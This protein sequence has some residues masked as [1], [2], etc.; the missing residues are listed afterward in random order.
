M[1]EWFL[2][3]QNNDA[4][5]LLSRLAEC[6][7]IF[8]NKGATA[9]MV[10]AAQGNLEAVALLIEMEGSVTR[11][12][13]WTALMEAAYHGQARVVQMLV[14]DLAGRQLVEEDGIFSRGST[15]LIVAATLGHCECVSTLLEYEKEIS[16][17]TDEFIQ[18]FKGQETSL[19]TVHDS[20][21]RTPLMYYAMHA[22]KGLFTLNSH[23]RAEAKFSA[24]RLDFTGY[25]ALMHAVR[26]DNIDFLAYVLSECSVELR[27]VSPR[28]RMYSALMMAAEL[29]NLEASEL[30]VSEEAGLANPYGLCALDIAIIHGHYDI[31][32]L[33]APTEGH[34][35]IHKECTCV[36]RLEPGMTP[37]DI[38]AKYG[39]QEMVSILSQRN[40][41]PLT[42]STLMTGSGSTHPDSLVLLRSTVPLSSRHNHDIE[43]NQFS[44][45]PL[46]TNSDELPANT[47]DD[48]GNI[49]ELREKLSSLREA[50]TELRQRLRQIDD[51]HSRAKDDLQKLAFSLKKQEKEHLQREE[52][53]KEDLQTMKDNLNRSIGY[54][55]EIFR[56]NNSLRQKLTHARDVLM[57]LRTERQQTSIHDTA[58][59]AEHALLL[60]ELHQ[61]EWTTLGLHSKES[62][63]RALIKRFTNFYNELTKVVRSSPQQIGDNPQIRPQIVSEDQAD[64]EANLSQM[65]TDFVNES[66]DEAAFPSTRDSSL[67]FKRSSEYS[68]YNPEVTSECS[69]RY[70]QSGTRN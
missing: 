56:E 64:H 12:T 57:A 69:E 10:A 48:Y 67:C 16:R 60:K 46:V 68:T 5:L 61:L 9:L 34:I 6:S 40:K 54:S 23:W 37:T 58:L 41:P 3:A 55:Q 17:W 36:H 63:M 13:G 35:A 26:T 44:L 38:A 30:L 59:L 42:L 22:H 31:V 50:N 20:A 25:S 15:A 43:Y 24:G 29:G 7:G 49:E 19:A 32:L 1:N 27:I 66:L 53:L 8:N 18:L 65:I 47:S 11:P 39:S 2:A 45:E 21:G 14:P 33:L 52:A 4:E 62:T 28:S 51:E 70:P